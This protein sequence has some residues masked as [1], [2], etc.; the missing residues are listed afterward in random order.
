MSDICE[1]CGLPTELCVCKEVTKD[2]FELN[3]KVENKK[4]N[5]VTIISGFDTDIIDLSD[6]ASML[7]E[8]LACGG[9]TYNNTIELQ[10]H[11]YEKVKSILE[12]KDYI[13]NDK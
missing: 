2:N 1:I 4:Y 3:I 8:K 9:T 13:I 12:K 5:D 6:V 7:K 10:G 11:H